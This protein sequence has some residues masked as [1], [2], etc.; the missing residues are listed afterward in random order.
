MNTQEETTSKFVDLYA[1]GKT[2]KEIKSLLG[3]S[4]SAQH[5]L[6]AKLGLPLRNRSA[7]K[8]AYI[9]AGKKICGG[10]TG[11]GKMRS[12]SSFYFR[13]GGYD[14]V[15][16]YCRKKKQKI[17]QETDKFKQ[18]NI[19]RTLF[20]T[21][22]ITIDQYYELEKLQNGLCKICKLPNTCKKTNRLYVD[23]CH[24]T[25]AIRGLLCMKCNTGLGYF[26]DNPDKLQAAIT[27]LIESKKKIA[28]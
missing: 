17:R 25:G 28:S 11:C 10:K 15:C 27:Y 26:D 8:E 9:A 14:G 3:I 1:E 19:N 18:W 5:K 20:K 6:R 16:Y 4:E 13:R 2:L 7:K 21:Y 23:H 12:L 24:D 22:G